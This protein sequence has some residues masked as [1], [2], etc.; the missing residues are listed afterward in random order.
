M[1]D[2]CVLRMREVVLVRGDRRVLEAVHWEVADGQRWVVMGPNGAGKSTLLE[3]ASTYEIPSRGRID[4]LGHRVGRVDL[5]ELRRRIG[6]AGAPLAR[7]IRPELTAIEAVLTGPRAMLTTFRQSFDAD[8]RSHALRLLA[9]LGLADVTDRRVSR[10]SE[11]ERQRVQVART[12]MTE[13][14]L[15]LLDEPT[16]SLD[17]AGREQLVTRL[18]RLRADGRPRAVVLVTHHLEEIPA[19]AT[20]ALLLRDGRVLAAGSVEATLTSEALSA[21]FGVA[22]QV[23]RDRGRWWARARD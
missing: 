8:E 21:C 19:S 9:E 2:A 5:R 18:G 11:G 7:R 20:H 15:L 10:L 3:L 22:L 23:G 16:A 14:E 4:V 6:Y 17:V 13:P 1:G 12:L